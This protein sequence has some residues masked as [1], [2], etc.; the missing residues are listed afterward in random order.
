MTPIRSLP[1]GLVSF[2][3]TDIEGSTEL[4]RRLG[5]DSARWV[6][7]HRELVALSV[8]RHD[9]QVFGHEGDA[10]F[11]AFADAGAALAASLDIQRDIEAEPWPPQARI[12]LRIGVH[13]GEAQP[14]GDN[15]IAMAVHQAARVAAASHG[16]QVLVSADTVAALG[17]ALPP[18]L[19]LRDLGEFRLKDFPESQ[20]LHQLTHVELRADFPP[21]RGLSAS[22]HNLPRPGT[23]FIGRSD[24]RAS[25]GLWL[26]E[27]PIVSLVGAGGV[28][29]TRLALEL[30]GDVLPHYA[31]G[32][33]L[34][35]LAGVGDADAAVRVASSLFGVAEQAGQ[36]ALDSLAEA[37]AGRHLLLLLD[38]CEHLLD[39]AGAI[40]AAVLRNPASRVLVTSRE[41]LR[42]S[43]EKVVR[44]VPLATQTESG[45]LSDA[46]RLFIE[47]AQM[48][49]PTL[50]LDSA[51]LQAVGEICR[52]LDGMP[53]ALE[54]AAGR[55]RALSL[56]ELAARLRD[57]L[58]LLSGGARDLSAR[59]QTLRATVEWSYELLSSAERRLFERLS[60]FADGWDLSAAEQVC[61]DCE[62]DAGVLD[63]LVALVDKSMVSYGEQS[64]A[65]Y[66]LLETLR[67]FAQEKQRSA[68]DA[69]TVEHRLL[70]WAIELA[71]SAAAQLSSGSGPGWMAR[72]LLEQN[73]LRAALE[74]G[75]RH[76]LTERT[77]RLTA[78]L[79]PFWIRRGRLR[80]GQLW[81]QRALALGGLPSVDR[82]ALLIGYG[83]LLR[84]SGAGRS[85]PVLHEA[86]AM[87]RRLGEV[88]L[89]LEALKQLVTSVRDRGDYGAAE[90]FMTEQYRLAQGSGD[91]Y[92]SFVVRTELATLDLQRGRYDEAATRLRACLLEAAANDWRWDQARMGNNLAIVL[93]ELGRADEAAR[94]GAEALL[95]F[96]ELGATEAVAHGASTTGMAL[97]R[98]HQLEAARALFIESGRI[99]VDVG[100]SRVVPEAL[101]RLAA[102]EAASGLP[103]S[104]ARYAAAADALYA[105]M[106]YERELA[107]RQLREGLQ[108]EVEARLGA[109]VT[110]LQDR[111][112]AQARQ[113]LNEALGLANSTASRSLS[114]ARG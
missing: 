9:G 27:Y 107:D 40:A 14:Y 88:P 113:V 59:H 109:A 50:R 62:D 63:R 44:L 43:Q 58:A 74:A 26:R 96:R 79:A 101:E 12:R 41:P 55:A 37:L 110:E 69:E 31:D 89:Q 108:R 70:D 83:R 87:A 86:L 13:A 5:N 15:Y 48:H 78:A 97:L 65:R 54:L 49:Q 95:I 106:G 76:Q 114:L 84:G 35:E 77:Q 73:N 47:R 25:V 10:C 19:A 105:E 91:V 23:S 38:N 80:E 42:L 2:V 45:E 103:A 32:A 8:S 93:M 68:P 17:G 51:A 28:G 81:A 56:P 90:D 99:A 60:V 21:P 94:L 11:C 67:E 24:E 111:A 39:A 102:V 46:A 29:K 85:E 52:R 72:L 104:A 34:L 18:G 61:G 16:G 4:L 98:Q 6:M 3:M 92:R 82:A 66:H 20:R 7:R 36:S 112:R 64:Q 30:A 1:R 100:A 53:L 57:R 22:R 71:E 33:W 75:Y